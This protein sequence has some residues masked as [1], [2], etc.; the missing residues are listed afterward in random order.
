MVDFF[1]AE[2]VK[3]GYS[4]DIAILNGISFKMK[5]GEIV[6]LLGLNGSGKTTFLKCVL[7]ELKYSGQ[8][9]LEGEN[10]SKMSTKALAA[11]VG[12]IPQ[13]EGADLSMSV[14]D[15]VLMGFYDSIPL[16]LNPNKA[17]KQR[18]IEAIADVGLAGFENRDY[19]S[20]SGGERQLVLI[21]R[22][23]LRNCGLLVLD[24]PD[25]SLDAKNK[26]TV[27]NLLKERV[28][29]EDK[30]ILLAMHDV[31]F[32]L[33]FCDRL[34]LLENGTIGA[35][36]CLNECNMDYIKSAL[37]RVYG[38]VDVGKIEK[39]YAAVIRGER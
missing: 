1:S 24:E 20:L 36:I 32:A 38:K 13:K 5:K 10:L 28:K 29:K 4:R 2:G 12:Y 17:Q 30:S 39:S 26:V 23:L 7:G 27:L 11:K 8:I 9:L 16:F 6:G 15:V 37:E 22:T 35:D 3:Y 34:I 33:N 19:T 25:S 14:V 18:A 31:T 21:A